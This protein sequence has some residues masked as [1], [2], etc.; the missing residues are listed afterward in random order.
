MSTAWNPGF[1]STVFARVDQVSLAGITMC[2]PLRA[3]M[4]SIALES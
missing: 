3:H 2:P 1:P 4:T